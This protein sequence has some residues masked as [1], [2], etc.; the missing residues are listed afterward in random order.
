[1]FTEAFVKSLP[2][3]ERY[4]EP[5]LGGGAGFFAIRPERALL[6]DVNPEVV[7]LYEV[8]RYHSEELM[9]ALARH[10]L[11]HSKAYYYDVRASSPNTRLDAA[12]RTLYLN[13]TCWNG[14]YRLN[15]RG[16]FN[17][18]IGTKNTVVLP[19]DD[20]RL[21]ASLLRNVVLICGD[22]TPAIDQAGSGDLVFVD[23]PYTVAH[24]VNGFVKYNEKIFT[25]DDQVRLR[26][27]LVRASGRGAKVILT[28]ANHVSVREL[29]RNFGQHI[30]VYR[31]SVISGTAAGRS[32]VSELL[33]R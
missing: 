2:S 33:V 17:V 25:W 31:R 22:F 7:Q 26:D 5:F 29:Y 4:V 18:P 27:A 30:E 10:Q 28:N 16:E 11:D 23:P 15:L 24:N 21:A 6:S 8:L 13:R 1:M 32:A 9:Q 3:F 14:L 19:T 12:A 20:F